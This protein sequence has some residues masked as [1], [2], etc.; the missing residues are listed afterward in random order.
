MGKA[1]DNAAPAL[2]RSD[3]ARFTSKTDH[4]KK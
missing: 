3:R 2:T 1:L 4:I